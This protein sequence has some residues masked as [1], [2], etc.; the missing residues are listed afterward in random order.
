MES[1]SFCA[2]IKGIPLWRPPLNDAPMLYLCLLVSV[3]VSMYLIRLCLTPPLLVFLLPILLSFKCRL[4][5]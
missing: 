5:G 4:I 3:C 2:P 1:V